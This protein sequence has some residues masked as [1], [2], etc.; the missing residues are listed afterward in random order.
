MSRWTMKTWHHRLL[1][2]QNRSR[3][4]LCR[5]KRRMRQLSRPQVAL[6]VELL[7]ERTLL[8]ATLGSEDPFGVVELKSGGNY[9]SAVMT[10]FL[11]VGQSRSDLAAEL[12]KSNFP[13]KYTASQAASFA[14]LITVG[15]S[16][17]NDTPATANAVPLGFDPAEDFA[18]DVTGSLGSGTDLAVVA[19]NVDGAGWNLNANGNISNSTSLPHISIQ[20]TGDGTFDYYSFTVA[21]AGDQAVFDIDFENF[22]TELFLYDSSGNLLAQND[23][24]GSDPGS[25]GFLASLI[26]ST[27][28]SPGTYIIGVGE[29][30]SF[31][32]GG[33]IGGNT[34]DPGDAYTLHISLQ[35]H[36]LNPG[37]ADPVA[38]VEPNHLV[39]EVDF[40]AI[41]LEPGDI[42]GANVSGGG[43]HLTFRAPDGSELVGSGQDL[44]FI[45]PVASPLPGGGN[46]ALSYVIDTT[47]T[48][49]IAVD[50]GSGSYTLNLR[51]FRPELESQLRRNH[52]ILFLDFDGQTIN[53]FGSTANL[54]PLSAF[55]AGW[56]LTASDEDAVIDAITAVVQENFDDVGLIGNN[57]DFETNGIDGQYGIEVVTS[58]DSTDAFGFPLDL[59]SS[60]NVSRVIVGGTI[61]ELGIGTIGIAESIDVG[62]FETEETAVVLLD[63]LSAASSNPNSLN[64]FPLGG[65]AT[66]IDLIGVG[67]GNIVAHEAG[68]FFANWHTFQ[69]NSVANIMDQGGNLAGLIGL[70]LDGIFGTV[71]DVDVDFGKD[72][73]VPDEGYTGTEDTLNSIAFGLSTGAV[74][75]GMIVVGSSPANNERIFAAPT[76]FV[77]DFFD[78]YDPAT[79][80]PGDL[81]V[82]GVAADSVALTDAD[83]LTFQFTSS[84]ATQGMNTLALAADSVERL[85]DGAG[86]AAFS[87]TFGFDA[88]L[89]QVVAVNPADGSLVEL[90]LTSLTVDFNEPYD[91]ASVG[92]NDLVLSQGSVTG[93][94]FV[95]ADTVEYTLDGILSEGPFT[96]S[97]PD[98]SVTDAF[99]NFFGTGF[100][101]SYTLDFGLVPYP[102]P[103]VPKEPLG[104]LIYD[105]SLSGTIDPAGDTDS[106]L[107]SVDPGQTITVV[108]ESDSTLL[109]TIELVRTD[110]D[111]DVLLGSATAA[112]PGEDAVIQT[113]P[114]VGPLGQLGPG[115]SD[116][117]VTVGGVEGTVGNYNVQFILNAAVEDESHYGPT[118]D[119]LAEAQNL[120]A[121]FIP[122]HNALNDDDTD[123][124]P[125]RGAVL[126]SMETGTSLMTVFEE[127]F[128]T[129]SLGPEWTTSSSRPDG[130][131]LVSNSLG[132]PAHSGSFHLSMD[133]AGVGA[134]LFN[135][136]EAIL[137]VDL[138]GFD[139]VE[140][141]FWQKDIGDEEHTLPSTFVGSA[142]GDGV[143]ISEDGIT[144]HTLVSPFNAENNTYTQFTFDLDEAAATAGIT[145]GQDFKIKFQ[146]FDNFPFDTDGRTFDD[147][148]LTVPIPAKDLY[149]FDL[150]MGESATLA[151]TAQSTG[152]PHVDLLDVGGNVVA[153]GL[154]KTPTTATGLI[155]NGSFETGDFTGWTVATMGSPFIDWQVT[156]G[157]TGAGF[158]MSPT[159]PQDGSF[160]AWN[161]FD[162]GGPMEFSMFQDVTIPAE[163]SGVTLEWQDRVR[164]NFTPGGF[165]SLPRLYDVQVRDP[166]T[167]AV[168]DTLFSFSTGTQATNPTGDTGWQTHTADLSAFAGST[169]R[170]FFHEEIP[171]FFTGPAQIEFDGISL[172]TG[173]V[174]QGPT[175][176]D[177]IISNFVAPE[178]GTYFVRVSGGDG[179][180]YSLVVT[181][182]ADFSIED[183]NS[184][185]SAQEVLST[186]AAGRQWVLGHILAQ[187][188]DTT[189][190]AIDSG[191]WDSNGSHSSSN[192]NY[193]VGL[194]GPTREFHNFFVFDLSSV[195]GT[196]VSAELGLF[197]QLI[198]YVSVDP[199]ETYSVFDV[200]TPI[201]TLRAGGFGQTAIFD[202]LGT[203]VELGSQVI[204]S[205]DVGQII[206]TSLNADGLAYLSANIGGQVA[207]GGTLTSISGTSTQVVF[208]FTGAGLTRRLTVGTLKTD[209]YQ[210]TLGK[211]MPLEVETST[212][213]VRSGEFVNEFDP[214]IRLYDAAG[215]L[216]AS[217][218]NSASDGRNAQ[219]QFKPSKGA[220]G[221]Y[222]IEV[223]GAGSADGEYLLSI[224]GNVAGEV[225]D[226]LSADFNG[227]GFI[228]GADF[229]AWQ[230]GFG[231][232]A[233]NATRADGDADGNQD[234]DGDDLDVWQLQY[235]AAT[236][237]VAAATALIAT[238]PV[239]QPTLTSSELVDVALAGVL[240]EEADGA[241]DTKETVSHL[242]P[243]EFYSTEPIRPSDSVSD[244]SISSSAT[245]S[246]PS[247]DEGQSP[248]GPSPWEDEVDEVFASIFE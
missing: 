119:T 131:I 76:D 86:V 247:D 120:E 35:N 156:G 38:E 48:Y 166:S 160:V 85:S 127:G 245:T 90:P 18:V 57:G 9:S 21:N 77:I 163:V 60:S 216:V 94:N 88:L 74:D 231:T 16:E 30:S 154:D 129:G 238:E 205:G 20:G 153:E 203:G 221:T 235:G 4:R 17:S 62:N 107:I 202:D 175:N 157:G 225:P 27:F 214:M 50:Q 240:A 24:N 68:H 195:S 142:N 181:R 108:V 5:A 36:G 14:A 229:L 112:A 152:A 158:G 28:A 25:G 3:R 146:Q 31:D 126:G 218:D 184:I 109:P 65:G 230:R 128:E 92:T 101:A 219:L 75:L 45:H 51:V 117:I 139:E 189:L 222:F 125:E 12:S 19:Q 6:A 132:T 23:D 226:T 8:A 61:P 47:G 208:G 241:S 172:N 239:A 190:Q 81:S 165:A 228:T 193:I 179:T 212:P 199:N 111:G 192:E 236:P 29:F 2:R 99:G 194:I 97:M 223:L 138:S 67:V 70:G 233:P 95:D 215:N 204:S 93:F 55:L 159:A 52:Q 248:E 217:D 116:Y 72:V 211:G 78:P 87:A 122:L 13:N 177:S 80:N 170:L 141:S 69:F 162:G 243:L 32:D 220:E 1:D 46:A 124:Q 42:F 39:A 207:L 58:R 63:L 183:N 59:F 187:D 147:I 161:G 34:P 113:A 100:S 191:W 148:V 136:N 173:E 7:E 22:D 168:L 167:N 82:N 227:D 197:N 140:F 56:G 71:D 115:P 246:T 37:G 145:L 149:S 96:V 137:T 135:L 206:A 110:D 26:N 98:G 64:Q 169:V 43:T 143:A 89:L 54:S 104:S 198:S 15:E 224:Q 106:F 164:W 188:T 200:S 40:F 41:D 121:S 209:F 182:S 10:A 242:L 150:Q 244:L 84:P 210:V 33:Q 185:D 134:P 232:L 151:L 118:N 105:P 123:L 174:S 171:E 53:T 114:T 49:T 102:V 130:R 201:S 178:T 11:P 79:V 66:I 103:L 144:W 213:A 133:T 91:Q 83:T 155:T 196:V 176:V 186:P 44:T 180:D 73:F 234:V 237:L